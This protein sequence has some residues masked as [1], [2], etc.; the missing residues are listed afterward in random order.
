MAVRPSPKRAR[1]MPVDARAVRGD[2]TCG[3]A[4]TSQ[5]GN[6]HE[7]SNGGV[8]L[9]LETL[10]GDAGPGSEHASF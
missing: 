2:L 5:L 9:E 10:D 7:H 1:A 4:Q 3:G 6:E 8:A